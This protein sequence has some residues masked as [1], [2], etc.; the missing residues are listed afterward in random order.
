MKILTIEDLP[1]SSIITKGNKLYWIE[2]RFGHRRV[3]VG[4]Q[5][6]QY[7]NNILVSHKNFEKCVAKALKELK[8]AKN[9]ST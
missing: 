3:K 7:Y 4:M 2:I 8:I 1:Q 5:T 9:L 6:K